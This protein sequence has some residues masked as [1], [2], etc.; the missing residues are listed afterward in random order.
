MWERDDFDIKIFSDDELWRCAT[1]DIIQLLEHP[2]GKILLNNFLLLEDSSGNSIEQRMIKRYRLST[3]LLEDVTKLYCTKYYLKFVALSPSTRWKNKVEKNLYVDSEEL[4]SLLD[5][6]YRRSN[7]EL[8][9]ESVI[10]LIFRG[11]IATEI[12]KRSEFGAQ[13]RLNN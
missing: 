3:E 7:K 12:K 11:Y 13:N 6:F 8:R 9:D 5:Q 2:I 10:M 4:R 1:M